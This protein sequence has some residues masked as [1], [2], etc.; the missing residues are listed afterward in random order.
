M[1]FHTTSLCTLGLALSV[2]AWAQQR[3]STPGLPGSTPGA[4]TSPFPSN[5]P[6]FP[7]SRPN[8][9]PGIGGLDRPVFLTGK[10]V[11]EDGTVPPDPIAVQIVCRANPRTLAFTDHKGNFSIDL[12]DRNSQVLGDASE[13]TQE[14]GTTNRNGTAPRSLCPGDPNLMGASVQAD[15]AGFR[16]DVV[17]LGVRH[18]LDNPDVGT[19]ILHRL[20]NVEGLTISATSA[21]A[22]KAAQKE[23]EKGRADEA[24]KKYPDA[25]KE[26]EKAV[27]IY[28]KYA[29]AWL[30]LGNV[31]RQGKDIEGA[32]ASYAKALAADP[33]FVSPY[34][35]LASIS[36]GEKN[37]QDAADE[38]DRLLRL[39]PVDF[40][41]AWF[42]NALS[43]YYLGKKEQAEKS[44]REGIGYDPA[45]RFPR[46]QYLLGVLLAQ[47]G[48]FAP[49]VQ[50]M[51]EY[52][53]YEPNAPDAADIQKQ[54]AE[55]DKAGGAEAKKAPT[56]ET[57]QQ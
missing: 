55:V 46:M 23:L 54:I 39:N 33:K 17:N 25:Q 43:N 47:K 27:A 4:S 41:Q 56:P 57:Q 26:F 42:Y 28:P 36:V 16:S 53:K 7:G 29:A 37:W 19:I 14:L 40:P 30:E 20:A 6:T 15:L 2:T 31:Q 18:G 48:Q 12:T 38:T 50:N 13:S 24:K 44:A 45:H 11:L 22:P 3:P 5:N 9:S 35:Q 10:V 1:N 32:R 52:L 34:V 8:N 51:R 21:L 49:A